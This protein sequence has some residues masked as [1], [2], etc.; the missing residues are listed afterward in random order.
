MTYVH[1]DTPGEESSLENEF[2]AAWL[3]K[4]RSK[5]YNIF[6]WYPAHANGIL[7]NEDFNTVIYNAAKYFLRK[8]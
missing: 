4:Y 7:S 1:V 3:I 2:P 8:S 5:G 6:Y